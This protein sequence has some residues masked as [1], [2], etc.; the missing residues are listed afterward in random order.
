MPNFD[1]RS[2]MTFKQIALSTKAENNALHIANY[3]HSAITLGDNENQ[4]IIKLI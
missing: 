4:K 1:L 2:C 3:N